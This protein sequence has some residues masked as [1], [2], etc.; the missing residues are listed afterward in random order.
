MEKGNERNS[1]AFFVRTGRQSGVDKGGSLNLPT[2]D[3][4]V[5]PW[6]KKVS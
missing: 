2:D 4:R 1:T 5:N 6:E 3:R